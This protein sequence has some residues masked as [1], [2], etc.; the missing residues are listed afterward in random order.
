M[1]GQSNGTP[2]HS[3]NHHYCLHPGNNLSLTCS[4]AIEQGRDVDINWI[5]DYNNSD[6]V[7]GLKLGGEELNVYE[8]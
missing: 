5:K 8:R 3:F 4:S 1:S 6:P 7:Q 2:L